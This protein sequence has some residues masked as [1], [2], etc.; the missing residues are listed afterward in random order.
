MRENAP[1]QITLSQLQR[2]IQEAVVERFP[3][4]LWV[5][6]E[7][8][9]L[10]VNGSGHCYLELVEKGVSDG[11]VKAQVRGV[12]WRG[13]YS[14][15]AQRFEQET[16]ISLSRGIKILVRATVGYHEL[17]G[18]SLTISDIDPSYTLGEVER[19]RQQAIAKLKANGSWDV[20]RSQSLPMLTQR[21]A[22]VSSR[23]AAGY[24]D[25][26]QELMRSP[27]RV[28]TTLFDSAMQGAGA[29]ESIIA[30]LIEIANR[31]EEF[32]AVVVI[33]GGGST[34]DLRCFDSYRLALHFARF[35]LP[36]V[37]GIGHERDISVV[38]MVAHTTLKTPTAV[39]GWLVE[40][41]QGLD[42]WLQRA[43][44]DILRQTMERT[45]GEHIRLERLSQELVLRCEE[46]IVR[47]RARQE[48]FA[49]L[50]ESFSPQ[51]LLEVGFAVVRQGGVVRGSVGDLAS[52]DTITIELVDGEI[53]AQITDVRG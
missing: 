53:E 3:L 19:E 24:E 25:F 27:Y 40:R 6:A 15:I 26:M 48:H 52:G 13:S 46:R 28:E 17:Y 36:V 18:M 51:R 50:I 16:G 14:S 44:E 23:Q 20:N 8:S 9:D 30:S 47:E 42:G 35:P 39:A 41:M 5:S 29:E 33:R 38:D 4:S 12:I 10:K 2:S 11:V 31:R 22:I 43:G 45:R 7:V 34:N 1:Q 37:A 49:T 32:D 21:L